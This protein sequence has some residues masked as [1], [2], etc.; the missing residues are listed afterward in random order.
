MSNNWQLVPKEPTREMFEAG[1]SSLRSNSTRQ[2]NALVCWKAM[3]AAAPALP[4]Y[5]PT[6]ADMEAGLREASQIAFSD[7]ASP[8]AGDDARCP[9][10]FEDATEALDE[11]GAGVPLEGMPP[12]FTIE[13]GVIH[14]RKTGKH[15]RT[16][17]CVKADDDGILNA[18]R[19]LN[20][21]AT[22]NE[23][24]AGDDAATVERIELLHAA[25]TEVDACFEAALCEGWTEALADGDIEAIRDLYGRR[26]SY[27]RTAAIT[28][29]TASAASPIART[30]ERVEKLERQIKLAKGHLYAVHAVDKAAFLKGAIGAALD[31]LSDAAI[32]AARTEEIAI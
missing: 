29:L 26:I 14:D 13:H 3:L 16:C 8:V 10:V 1:R 15:V 9:F 28:V 20:G 27:A 12:R 24:K 18:V 5:A 11:I 31:C 6:V 17:D 21:L 19:L 32:A 22:A 4:P 7:H 2:A 30:D 25:L 23:P